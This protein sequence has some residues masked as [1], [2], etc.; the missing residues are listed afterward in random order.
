MILVDS[1]VWIDHFRHGNHVLD[2]ILENKKVIS[3]TGVVLLELIPFLQKWKDADEIQEFLEKLPKVEMFL[4]NKEWEVLV[5][6]Q[7]ML[8]QK[9][10]NGVGIPDLIILF[11]SKSHALPLLTL[12]TTMKKA[13]S[14]LKIPLYEQS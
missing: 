9:G 3:T 8:I 6:Y 1:S 13:A 10:I 4:I 12:D 11:V 7:S 2:Q 14:I 5:H